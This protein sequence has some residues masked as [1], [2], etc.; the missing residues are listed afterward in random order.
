MT[1]YLRTRARGRGASTLIAIAFGAPGIVMTTLIGF[2]LYA[3]A[4][5]LLSH[6]AVGARLGHR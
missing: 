2:V 1:G 6:P 3:A 4:G 5:T